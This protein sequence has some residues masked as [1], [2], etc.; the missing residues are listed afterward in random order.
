MKRNRLI[1]LFSFMWGNGGN[2]LLGLSY[3]LTLLILSSNNFLFNYVAAISLKSITDAIVNKDRVLLLQGIWFLFKGFGI[4]VLIFPFIG[5]VY[6]YAV[7]KTTMIIRENLFK[8]IMNLPMRE[9]S[10]RH[11]GD[12]LSRINFDVNT[13]EGVYSWQVMIILSSTLSAIGSSFIIFK[14][15]KIIFIYIVSIGLINVLINYLFMNSIRKIS[16]EIQNTF[17]KITQKL[18]DIIGGAFIIRSFNIGKIIFDKYMELNNS[19][20][21]LSLKRVK[22][23]SFLS[24]LNY[25]IG[26]LI[27]FGELALGGLI[28][29]YNQITFGDLIATVQLMGPIFWFFGN[30]GNFIINLQTSLAGAERVFEVLDLPSEKEEIVRKRK[31]IV[32]NNSEIIRFEDVHFSYDGDEEVLKGISFSIDEKMKVAFVGET[33][34]GKST[35]FKLL[36]GFYKDYQGSIYIYGKELRNYSIDELRNLI[37][38]V[39]Q[40]VYL[41]NDTILE[42]VRYGKLD[43]KE[44]DVINALKLANAYEFVERLPNGIYTKVGERGISLSGGQR[45]R[46]AI[47][48]GILKNSPILLLDEATSSLDS[49]SEELVVQALRN[50]MKDKTTLIIAHRLSTIVDADRIIVIDDGKIIEEGTHEELISLNSKYKDLWEKSFKDSHIKD[51][52]DVHS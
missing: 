37:S 44:E 28:I 46:I 15:N 1:R 49:E 24:S 19:L 33:G 39:P 35:I 47:A 18:S 27:F 48:R 29:F 14:I 20:Y 5:Y 25:S 13:A 31:E 22:Y 52:L 12:F 40:D 43:A 36:L 50:L 38:Y 10:K 51:T 30:L 26:T 4:M 6:Q 42:N 7:R 3:L 17:S 23:F 34:G 2:F 8:H 45:Q 32:K 41:F 9:I 16:N 21:K 11:S